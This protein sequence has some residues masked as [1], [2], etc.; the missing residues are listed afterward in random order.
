MQ[1]IRDGIVITCIIRVE[2]QSNKCG[3]AMIVA[4]EGKKNGADASEAIEQLA[5]PQ[6]YK[7]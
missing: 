1:K 6:P 4:S 2:N 5:S 3:I 7:T